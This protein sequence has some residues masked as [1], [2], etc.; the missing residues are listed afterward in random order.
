[1]CALLMMTSISKS[2]GDIPILQ[3]V[4]L[5]LRSGEFH[6]LVGE[7]GAGKSTLVRILCGVTKKDKGNI[8]IDNQVVQIGSPKDAIENGIQS[9]QQDTFLF[10]SMTVA[11]NIFS[12]QPNCCYDK[13]GFINRKKMN[14]I[15]QDLIDKLGFKLNCMQKVGKLNLAQKR[16]VELVRLFIFRPDF[17]ILDEP[18][19]SIGTNEAD[20]L[21]HLLED[22]RRQGTAV[23]YVSQRIKEIV[24]YA[25]RITVMRDGKVIDSKNSN[26]TSLSNIDK[27][28]WGQFYPNRY[29]KLDIAKGPEIFCIENLS[30]GN[31]L[32]DINLNISQGEILGI[33]GLVG[34]GRSQLAKTIFGLLPLKSGTFYIDRLKANI[35]SPRDAISL[36][37]AYVTE[38]RYNEGLFMNLNILQNVF[39]IENIIK[40]FFI[41]SVRHDSLIYK[42]YEKKINLK[43]QRPASSPFSLSGGMQQKVLLMRWFLTDARI[44]IFDEPTRGV[45]IP[46]KVDIYNLMNDLVRK[47]GAIILI[48]SNVEELVGMCDRILVLADG[49]IT[50]EAHREVPGEFNNIQNYFV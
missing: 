38:D 48:S 39:A 29:P 11:E 44:F 13:F 19:S 12:Q 9:V 50:H 31:L 40:R 3:D 41:S 26:E 5:T 2:I 15:S 42:K 8:Y 27:I 36:G 18:I 46:S 7:N 21:L 49:K 23:L 33:T 4:D 32:N 1:V 34:S 20:V 14:T 35:R 22:Y 17:L 45:D 30:S 43:P 25:S 6:L 24:K 37:L 16:M 28:V 47:K 10:D